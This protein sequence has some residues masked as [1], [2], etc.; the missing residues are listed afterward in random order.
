M[1]IIIIIIINIY[2]YYYHFGSVKVCGLPQGVSRGEKENSEK[3]QSK[4]WHSTLMDEWLRCQSQVEL[5][6][7]YLSIF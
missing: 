4:I 6:V 1:I 5:N 2:Y 3:P 7:L